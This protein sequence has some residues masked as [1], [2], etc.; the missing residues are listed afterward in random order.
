MW[1]AIGGVAASVIAG[2]IIWYVTTVLYPRLTSE[3]PPPP[4]AKEIMAQCDVTPPTVAPGGSTDVVVHVTRGGGALEGA[5]V[6]LAVGGGRF[7]SGSTKEE[8]RTY[9]GGVYRTTWTAPSPAA[10]GYNMPAIVNVDGMRTSDGELS[11]TVRTDCFVR[12][13]P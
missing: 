10:A 12:V 5:T 8:G 6:N 13:R 11:G 2:L 3:P 4:P 7:A 1:K 9:S